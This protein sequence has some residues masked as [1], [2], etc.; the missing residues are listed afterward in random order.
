MLHTVYIMRTNFVDPFSQ[1]KGGQKKIFLFLSL[2]NQAST[3]SVSLNSLVV[4]VPASGSDG[5]GSSP[6]EVIKK[7]GF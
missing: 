5:S 2:G 3:T 1:I 4:S 7:F 6:G